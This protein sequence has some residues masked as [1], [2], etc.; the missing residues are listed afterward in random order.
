MF[1]SEKC[2]ISVLNGCI[3]FLQVFIP[4][5]RVC[6]ALGKSPSAQPP[7]GFYSDPYS[8]IFGTRF[9]Q[10]YECSTSYRM[11]VRYWISIQFYRRDKDR[12]E[13]VVLVAH[14]D[15]CSGLVAC[16]LTSWMSTLGKRWLGDW[17]VSLGWGDEVVTL[18]TFGA[19]EELQGLVTDVAAVVA[20][21]V[22]APRTYQDSA[23]R[24]AE[25][26]V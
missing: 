12:G 10:R 13:K 25:M 14:V 5:P 2:H 6:T 1:N 20:K 8:C 4:P 16:M 21:R 22:S 26:V 19:V 7:P 23:V 24:F 3:V 11:L 18:G 15:W 9:D 17:Q